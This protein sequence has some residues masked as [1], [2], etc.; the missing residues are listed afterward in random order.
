[1]HLIEKNLDKVD[2]KMLCKNPNAIHLL[3]KYPEQV[4]W[5]LTNPNALHLFCDLDYARMKERIQPLKEELQAYFIH[6]D[7]LMRMA[8]Q[9]GVEFR[10]YLQHNPLYS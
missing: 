1:M 7:R 3:E 6:P 10:T 8:K 9:S 4:Q 5:T 2:W